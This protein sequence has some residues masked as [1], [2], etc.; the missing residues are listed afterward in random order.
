[1]QGLFLSGARAA[2]GIPGMPQVDLQKEGMKIGVIA[3]SAP[4]KV[5]SHPRG[6]TMWSSILEKLNYTGHT[7]P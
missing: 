7:S 5:R 3:V 1:M 2:Q 4:E 6:F